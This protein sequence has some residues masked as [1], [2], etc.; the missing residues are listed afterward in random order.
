[1]RGTLKG[2]GTPICRVDYVP[3]EDKVEPGEW[4]YTSGDD[5]I[6]PRGFP[7]GVVK[8]VRSASPSRRFWWIRAAWRA[9]WRTS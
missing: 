4:L 9:A 5:R 8:A 2:Q 1:V 7:V 3:F 6:F